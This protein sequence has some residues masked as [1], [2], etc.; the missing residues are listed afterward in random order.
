M[1]CEKCL[2]SEITFKNDDT[3]CLPEFQVATLALLPTII[4]VLVVDGATLFTTDDKTRFIFYLSKNMQQETTTTSIKSTTTMPS[5]EQSS[6]HNERMERLEG[7]NGSIERHT[8]SVDL[9]LECP[10]LEQT[11]KT[12]FDDWYTNTFLKGQGLENGCRDEWEDFR[13]CMMVS[14]QVV[15]GPI[16]FGIIP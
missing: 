13:A 12:C 15:E 1:D 4:V 10:K 9:K 11:Y 7:E 8:F 3:L 6:F 14:I 16:N 2:P 5:E